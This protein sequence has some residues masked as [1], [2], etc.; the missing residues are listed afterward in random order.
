M[1]SFDPNILY[2]D[3]EEFSFEELRAVQN[4]LPCP[5]SQNAAVCDTVSGGPLGSD[6]LDNGMVV[7]A[8]DE[9]EENIE[10][11]LSMLGEMAEL[12]PGYFVSPPTLA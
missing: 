2:T 10:P 4:W 6:E 11:A 12:E 8:R 9:N 3:S 1:L 7:A 5:Q